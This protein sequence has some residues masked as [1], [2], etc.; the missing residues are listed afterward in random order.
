MAEIS[1]WKDRGKGILDPTLLDKQAENWA[2]SVFDD[3]KRSKGADAENNKPT[4]LRRFYDEVLRFDSLLKG[5][6]AESAFEKHL[7]YIKMMNAKVSYAKAR[8]HVS[9]KFAQMIKSCVRNVETRSDFEAFK[10]FFEAFMGYYRYLH[11]KN[12]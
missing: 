7:P 10:S 5:N 9:E 1:F 4:Q 11:P 12:N 3:A 2:Q 8:E 6:E